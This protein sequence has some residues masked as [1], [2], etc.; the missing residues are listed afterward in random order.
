MF[1]VPLNLDALTAG[2]KTRSIQDPK[3]TKI[4][5]RERTVLSVN[6]LPMRSQTEDSVL[7]AIKA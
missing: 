3:H 5:G 2:L 1:I 4:E 6:E 7:L